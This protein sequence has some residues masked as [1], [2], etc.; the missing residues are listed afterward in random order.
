M[1]RISTFSSVDEVGPSVLIFPSPFQLHSGD[2]VNRELRTAFGWHT[3]K[4][5]SA[6]TFG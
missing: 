5:V 6:M 4:W 3:A 2:T 1:L